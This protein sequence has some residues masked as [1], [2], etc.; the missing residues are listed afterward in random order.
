MVIADMSDNASAA[1]EAMADRQAQRCRD[2]KREKQI[3]LADLIFLHFFF[4]SLRLC[5][6]ALKI[7][8]PSGLNQASIKPESGL[9]NSNQA[10][11][12][13]TQKFFFKMKT[14]DETSR[15]QTQKRQILP[16]ALP[17]LEW[18]WLCQCRDGGATPAGLS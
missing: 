17:G 15:V 12:S 5:V 4:A 13:L 3:P 9:I 14:C 11:S 7:K 6:F 1:A 8:P 16:L 10:Y 2:A 18:R